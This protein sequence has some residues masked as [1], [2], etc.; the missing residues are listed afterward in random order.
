MSAV[1]LKPCPF[2][3]TPP[4]KHVRLDESLFSHGMVEWITITCMDCGISMSSEDTSVVDI[5]NIRKR[6]PAP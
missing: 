1:K 6:R 5:W 3:A 2:C 4:T